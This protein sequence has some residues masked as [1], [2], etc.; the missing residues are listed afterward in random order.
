MVQAIEKVTAPLALKLF[1]PLPL[2]GFVVFSLG[3]PS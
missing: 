3:L 1:F 2:Y